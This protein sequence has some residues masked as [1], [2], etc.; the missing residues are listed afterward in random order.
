MQRGSRYGNLKGMGKRKT[1]AGFSGEDS[2][3]REGIFQ[4]SCD[5]FVPAVLENQIDE[6]TALQLR[7]RVEVNL[8]L[9]M[10][11]RNGFED[12]LRLAQ[13]YGVSWWEA[14]FLLMVSRVVKTTRVQETYP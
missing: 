10:F 14:V 7:C 9:R 3:R 8:Y 13:E 1:V 11:M 5:I 2:I 12:Y 6:C 4:V